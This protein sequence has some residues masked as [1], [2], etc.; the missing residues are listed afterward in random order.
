MN[1][2]PG[3]RPP[4]SATPRR[5]RRSCALTERLVGPERALEAARLVTAFAHGFVSMELSGAFRLGGDVDEAYRYGVGVLVDAL[6]DGR[7]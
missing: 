3:S 6:T 4:P 5:P 2:P 7:Q 1:L